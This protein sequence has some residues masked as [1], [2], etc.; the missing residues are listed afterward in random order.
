MTFDDWLQNIDNMDN[1]VDSLAPSVGSLPA[2]AKIKV[3]KEFQLHKH[4]AQE[5]IVELFKA[6]QLIS[7]TQPTAPI[8]TFVVGSKT[9]MSMVYRI[10]FEQEA[11]GDVFNSRGEKMIPEVYFFHT[12]LQCWRVLRKRGDWAAAVV[13]ALERQESLKLM[14]TFKRFSIHEAQKMEKLHNVAVR[15]P[16]GQNVSYGLFDSFSQSNCKSSQQLHQNHHTASM[17]S[18]SSSYSP[19]MLSPVGLGLKMQLMPSRPGSPADRAH[20]ARKESSLQTLTDTT[21]VTDHSIDLSNSSPNSTSSPKS[22]NANFNVQVLLHDSHSALILPTVDV[23]E[24]GAPPPQLG[25]SS[26]SSTANHGLYSP[27]GTAHRSVSPPRVRTTSPQKHRRVELDTPGVL[28]TQ[29]PTAPAVV[30]T[31]KPIKEQQEKLA[32][33]LEKRILKTRW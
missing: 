18:N 24:L 33:I 32:E 19:R 20:P 22:L 4:L 29:L 5:C 10:I 15:S 14:Y 16:N 25:R 21:A 26:R 23:P 13:A 27:P 12:F 6:S 1:T 3:H 28:Y 11:P 9:P 7:S 2:K 17:S 30:S 8:Q 31:S